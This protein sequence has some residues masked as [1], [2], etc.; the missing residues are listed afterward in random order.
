MSKVT[1][2]AKNMKTD[3]RGLYMYLKTKKIR[4]IKH[5]K[6]NVKN[7]FSEMKISLGGIQR[8]LDNAKERDQNTWTEQ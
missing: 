7:I 3:S 2:L 5:K 8:R 6:T 1:K 4:E